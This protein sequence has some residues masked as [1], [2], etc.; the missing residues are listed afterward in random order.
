M[1]HRLHHPLWTLCQRL[2]WPFLQCWW[3]CSVHSSFH[4][5]QALCI[6]CK[7]P[8]QGRDSSC[9]LSGAVWQQNNQAVRLSGH[10]YLC[11][12]VV[13]SKYGGGSAGF[14]ATQDDDMRLTSQ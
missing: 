12:C 5:S 13:G 11:D 3:S 14:R 10:C 2:Y 4:V 9:R 6:W 1:V 7:V 8:H